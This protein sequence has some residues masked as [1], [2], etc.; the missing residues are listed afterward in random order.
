MNVNNDDMGLGALME[1][2]DDIK[3]EVEKASAQK[4]VRRG[5]PRPDPS[6]WVLSKSLRGRDV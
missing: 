6:K 2:L 5:D 4:T 3:R 1:V